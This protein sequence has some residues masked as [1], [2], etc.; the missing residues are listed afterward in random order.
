MSEYTRTLP[1]IDM[2]IAQIPEGSSR[3]KIIGIIL[4]NTD[5]FI[6]IGDST[7]QIV[8]NSSRYLGTLE[9]QEKGRFILNV[10]KENEEISGYLLSFIPMSPREIKTYERLVELEKRIP[11]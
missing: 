2:K 9:V 7:G 11:R 4:S 1:S 6:R 8:V 3:V 10:T 5:G